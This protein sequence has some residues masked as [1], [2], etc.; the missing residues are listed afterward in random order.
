MT[1]AYDCIIIGGGPAGATTATLL[2][3]HGRSALVLERYPFPRHRVGES[4]MPQ[5]YWTFKR[6]GM[7]EKLQAMDFPVKESVQFVTANGKESAPF[8]FTDRDPNEWSRTWQVRRDVFDKMMIDNAVANGAEV[9]HGANVREVIMDGERAKGVRAIV[10]G[11]VRE[12][13]AKVVVDASGQSGLL[14]RQLGLREPDERLKN[15]SIY[16]HYRNCEWEEGR[17]AGATIIMHTR[18]RNGWFWWIPLNEKDRL[19]SVGVVAPP[20]YL[21]TG[22]G[23]DPAMTLDEEIANCP[24]LQSRLGKAERI[25]KVYVTADFSYRSR[26]MAG[27]GWVLIGDAFGFLDPVYSSGV[28]LALKSG[29]YAADTIHKAL[30]LGDTS[31]SRLGAFGGRFVAAMQTLRQLVYA[32][33]NEDFSIGKFVRD[34]PK[35]G[36]HI[37]RILIGDVFNNEVGAVFDVMRQRIDLPGPIELEENAIA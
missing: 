26:R 2:A 30:E 8:F 36:D 6:L 18:D 15:A 1:N 16:A 19:V 14:S 21:C 34:N 7:L 28:M 37:V 9:I 23:D 35:F 33:Y 22:R 27:D 20:S 13:A 12:F 29:E 3:K 32:F 5:T 25:G 11:K 10:D 17:N 24:G 4:L 31:A